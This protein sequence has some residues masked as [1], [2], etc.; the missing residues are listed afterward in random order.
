MATIKIAESGCRGCTLCVEVCPVDVFEFDDIEKLA[1]VAHQDDCIGCLSCT[2]ECPSGCIG[3]SGVE[4]LRP[5][6]HI[7]SHA[8][9]LERFLQVKATAVAL[10]GEDWDE[11]RLDVAARLQALGSTVVETIG[12]GNRAVGRRAGALAAHHMP[13]MY[14]LQELDGVLAA[15]RRRFRV[16]FEF[17]YALKDGHATLDFHPCGLCRVVEGAGEKVGEAVLCHLFHEFWAGLL[18]AFVGTQYRYEVPL[19][20]KTCRMELYP[21]ST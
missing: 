9:L 7:E 11:A 21:S 14:E 2:F 13:E 10:G 15:M 20:G 12:R 17:D 19:A 8:A 6:H 3:I 16:A 4:V 5:F 18:T 1:V